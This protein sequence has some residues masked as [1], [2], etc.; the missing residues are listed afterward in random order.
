[1][2]KK[3]GQEFLSFSFIQKLLSFL[4]SLD[5]F[6]QHGSNLEQVTADAVVSNFKDG[7]I[8]VLV[9][10]DDA[11]GILHT[12]LV[13]DSAGDT[14]SNIDSGMYGLTGLTNL[15][16]NADPTGVNNCTGSTNNT[17]ENV[18]LGL[19]AGISLCLPKSLPQ[20]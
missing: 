16:V 13:L 9:N 20:K 5:S 2:N 14:E 10:S 1:M 17:A 11:F 18:F 19:T 4:S 8:F 15:L 6:N 12:G 7:S 3:E